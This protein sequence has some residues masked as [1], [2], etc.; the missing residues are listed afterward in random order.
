MFKISHTCFAARPHVQINSSRYSESSE[1]LPTT[2]AVTSSAVA[3][4]IALKVELNFEVIL[5]TVHYQFCF[6][7]SRKLEQN[8]LESAPI[9]MCRTKNTSPETFK[10]FFLSS[11][12]TTGT[13]FQKYR[14]ATF[15]MPP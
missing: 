13:Y 2:F 14:T 8:A 12:H 15:A 3:L 11:H 5:Y 9:I 10:F 7:N 6:I 4:L 1:L